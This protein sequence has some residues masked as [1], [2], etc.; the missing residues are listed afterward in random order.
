MDI[1]RLTQ[2]LSRLRQVANYIDNHLAEPLKLD[3]LADVACLSRFHF[4][5]VFADYSGETPLVRVRRLRLARARQR[6]ECGETSSLIEL[7]LDCGYASPEAFSRAFR[8]SFGTSPSALSR[9][10]TASPALMRIEYVAPLAIQYIRYRGQLDELLAPFDELRARAMLQEIPRTHRKGWS[11]HLSGNLDAWQGPMDIQAA[12]LSDRLRTRIP[13]LDVGR[14]PG[15][16][17]AIF[18]LAGS[19]DAPPM[20]ELARRIETETSWRLREAPFMR[21]FQ[22]AAHLPAPQERRFDL[23][24]PVSKRPTTRSK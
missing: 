19:Y 11:I 22:N 10:D 1:G 24:V 5:R 12:L 21:C 18:T 6:I 13:G 17:Y 16:H 9:A 8:T 14:L 3:D 4:E 23:Y 20:P 7:A 15:G 2:R